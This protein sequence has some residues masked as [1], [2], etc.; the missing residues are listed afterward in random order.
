MFISRIKE[1]VGIDIGSNSVKLVQVKEQK[2]TFSLLSV[3]IL[4]LPAEAI[5]D[6]T[7]MDSSSI[8]ETIKNLVRSLDITAK[9]A[10]SSISGNAVIIRKIILPSMSSEEL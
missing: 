9:D 3:G 5:V 2:G 10:A 6:N 1:T 7:L 4:P 8:V